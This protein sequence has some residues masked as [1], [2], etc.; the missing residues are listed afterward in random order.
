ME[1]CMVCTISLNMTDRIR[2]IGVPPNLGP[3]IRDAIKRGWGNG[4]QS[5]REYHGTHEFK[6]SGNPWYGTGDEAVMS[7]RLV[8]YILTAM[9]ANGWNLIQSSDVSKKPG[10]KDTLFFENGMPDPEVQIFPISFNMTDRIRVID[11]PAIIPFVKKAIDMQWTRGVQNEREYYGSHEFKLSGTPWW[12][13]GSETVM[14]RMLLTQILANLRSIG[15]KLY[16]SI[17][18]STGTE[19]NQDLESWYFRKT[20]PAWQ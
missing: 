14:A 13:D 15:F 16:G 2:L 1:Q 9:A 11:A 12:P 19:K 10:D 18:Q 8:A 20:G 7:R 6:L 5:E 3:I 4:I 17:D